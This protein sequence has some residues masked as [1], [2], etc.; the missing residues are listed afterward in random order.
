[1][2]MAQLID[3]TTKVSL[4]MCGNN[5]GVDLKQIIASIIKDIPDCEAGGHANAAG[6]LIPTDMEQ[7]FI[8]KA[9]VILEKKAME[10]VV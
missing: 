8:K 5:N 7:E 2:S 10:E 9:K 6:A 1:M 4:R 3:G